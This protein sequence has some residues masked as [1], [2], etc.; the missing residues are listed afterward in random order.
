VDPAE[1]DPAAPDPVEPEGGD[2]ACWLDQVCPACGRL[3][4]RLPS[5][6]CAA[7]GEVRDSE[8]PLRHHP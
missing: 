8:P 1:L 2:P 4:E 5:G 6:R 7:C 3:S